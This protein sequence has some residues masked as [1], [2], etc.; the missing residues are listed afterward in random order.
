MH[1]HSTAVLGDGNAN[2]GLSQAEL[3]ET[4]VSTAVSMVLQQQ[5]A[6]S[7]APTD[8]YRDFP[9]LLTSTHIHQMTGWSKSEIGRMLLDGRLPSLD[10]GGGTAH[11]KRWVSKQFM[12]RLLADLDAGK[13]VRLRE[14]ADRW[15]ASVRE[16]AEAGQ[17]VA[18]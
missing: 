1:V 13:P 6:P 14:Y 12:L 8:P 2:A 3:I 5:A 4:A 9:P 18:S 15:N 10:T 16:Q 7:Q 17:A 11:R